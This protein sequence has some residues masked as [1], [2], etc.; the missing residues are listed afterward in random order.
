[1]QSR[2]TTSCRG[3]ANDARL[4]R[5]VNLVIARLVTRDATRESNRG[6]V[7][8]GGAAQRRVARCTGKHRGKSEKATYLGDKIQQE[9]ELDSF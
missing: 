8:I 1:M 7:G 2:R 9:E 4:T 3:D 5:W 6:W